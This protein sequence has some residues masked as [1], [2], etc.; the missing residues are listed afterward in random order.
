MP[1]RGVVSIRSGICG[2]IACLLLLAASNFAAQ[3]NKNPSPA[4]AANVSRGLCDKPFDLELTAPS[5]AT[6]R[7]TVDGT[8][9]GAA[10]GRA[11][12]GRL[13]IT[14]TTLLRAAAFKDGKR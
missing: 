1:V 6:L 2:V 8:E 12:S 13:T 10:N 7:Y 3:P 9:P 5:G 4:I 11:F 14:N